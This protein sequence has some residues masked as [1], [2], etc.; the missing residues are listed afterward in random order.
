MLVTMTIMQA[1]TNEAAPLLLAV[2]ELSRR[3]PPSMSSFSF[4]SHF[5]L[6]FQV[7][8]WNVFFSRKA[9]TGSGLVPNPACLTPFAAL[10][11]WQSLC[12]S[13]SESLRGSVFTL[14]IFQSLH[15]RV[16]SHLKSK[17]LSRAKSIAHIWAALGWVLR[18]GQLNPGLWL[19]GKGGF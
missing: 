14:L 18:D 9:E 10:A 16:L 4:L 13:S 17:L 19:T 6:V 5:S 3:S 7:L 1:S 15:L 11:S 2:D 12:C 8:H